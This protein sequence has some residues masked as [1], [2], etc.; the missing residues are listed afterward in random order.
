MSA[1]RLNRAS[2]ASAAVTIGLMAVFPGTQ[3]FAATAAA[4]PASA[5]TD[6]AAAPV[7]LVPSMPEI[8]S[9]P[10]PAR[11]PLPAF[12]PRDTPARV[13]PSVSAPAAGA[14]AGTGAAAPDEDIRDIRGPRSIFP[15]WQVL[16]WIAVA[17]LAAL[18]GYLGWRRTRRP[19]APRRLEFFEIALQRLEGIR[20]LMQPAT[21]REFSIAISDV[22]RQY[23]EV[24]MKI[25]ATH[26]T[27][28]EFLRDLLDSA[29]ASLAA[30]R[31]LLAEFL[32]ACDMAKF[33]GVGLS[34][35]IMESL[36][37]SARGFVI[38]TSKP[39]ATP[40]LA[41]APQPVPAPQV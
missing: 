9:P 14:G 37:S 29:N 21:V 1:R 13:S 16:A 4:D 36:H 33:A 28:E 27:T 40:P 5:A 12:S 10:P 34:M 15:L 22:V 31:N 2:T 19:Q 39:V 38:E 20:P 35:R 3:P 32:Q 25:T 23:I 6:P 18:G 7:T 11:A 26:R 41:Q 24:Q 8:F 17:V 30:H